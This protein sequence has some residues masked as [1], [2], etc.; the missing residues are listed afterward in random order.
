MDIDYN[1]LCDKK[2]MNSFKLK[3]FKHP[4]MKIKPEI[5]PTVRQNCCTLFD[6]LAIAKL[7]KD[8]TLP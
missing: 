7:W 8:F 1:T 4:M 5:C 3:G 6:E 2:I